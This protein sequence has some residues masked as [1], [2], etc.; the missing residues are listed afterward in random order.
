MQTNRNAR[1]AYGSRQHH[2]GNG[3]YYGKWR[4]GERQ[5]MRKLGPVRKP[6]TRDGLTKTQAEARLRTLMAEVTAPPVTERIT[7]RGGRQSGSWRTWKR[8]A[9]SRRRSGPIGPSCSADRPAARR[10]AD[11]PRAPRG[12]RAVRRGCMRDGLVGQVHGQR[13]RASCTASSSSRSGAV[14]RAQP[15]PVRGPPRGASRRDRRSASST[16]PRSRRCF[17]RRP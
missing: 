1:R 9:A 2:R 10:S 5:I 15:V 14:G 4:V 12:H 17:A 6:G 13:A 7:V 11:R 16:R 8:W 3:V